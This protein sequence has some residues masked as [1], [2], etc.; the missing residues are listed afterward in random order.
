MKIA[1]LNLP[2][3]NNFGDNLQRYA[4][5]KVLQDMGHEVVHINLRFDY[6]LPLYKRPVYYA[7]RLLKKILLKRDIQIFDT[8]QSQ[9]EKKCLITDSFYQKYVP[10]TAVITDAKLLYN[11]LDYNAFVVGSD[12][13]WRKTIAAKNLSYFSSNT[14]K[15]LINLKLHVQYL[16]ALMQMN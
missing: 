1:L 11:Y 7:K 16:L 10:H 13:V 5:V 14:Y 6:R 4:L 8:P 3:D 9:Y 15:T 12:Q 2:V